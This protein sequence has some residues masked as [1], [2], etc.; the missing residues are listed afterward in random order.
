[1]TH[2]YY[3]MLSKNLGASEKGKYLNLKKISGEILKTFA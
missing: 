1:M 3:A 2:G